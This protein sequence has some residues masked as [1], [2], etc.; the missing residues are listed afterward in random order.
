KMV[1]LRINDRGPYI[2][3]RLIDLSYAAAKVIDLI[4]PGSGEVD[5]HIVSVGKGDR[6][7]PAPYT[8]TV[9]EAAPPL[10]EMPSVAAPAPGRAPV[11]PQSAPEAGAPTPVVVDQVQVIEEHHNVET[12]KQV[13]A[14]GRT[15]ETLAVQPAPQPQPTA[16]S[17]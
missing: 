11:T 1:R 2:G 14:N 6:E 9:A 8:V 10:V 7:P 3:N 5:L 4:E 13:A 15:I 16:N 17:H 12:R